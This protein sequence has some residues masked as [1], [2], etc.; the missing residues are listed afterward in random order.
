MAETIITYAQ[1]N[2]SDKYDL[3]TGALKKNIDRIAT[4]FIQEVVT[5]KGSNVFDRNYGT[6]FLDNLGSQVNVHKIDYFLKKEV[7]GLHDKYGIESVSATRAWVDVNEGVLNV[8]I[9]LEFREYAV[10]SFIDFRFLG[11]FVDGDIVEYTY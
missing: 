9:T 4:N 7:S 1:S 10:S 3:L 8:E 2:K 6:M 5:T 11:S